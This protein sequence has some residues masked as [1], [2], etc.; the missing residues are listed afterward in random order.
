[1]DQEA[2]LSGIKAMLLRAGGRSERQVLSAAIELL[3]AGSEGPAPATR[4]DEVEDHP[5]NG[6]WVHGESAEQFGRVSYP[7]RNEAIAEGRVLYAGYPF[8]T[9]QVERP[10]AQDFAPDVDQVINRLADSACVL[11][12]GEEPDYTA[13]PESIIAD[14]HVQLGGAVAAWADKWQLHPRF[15]NVV[16][17]ERHVPYV[18]LDRE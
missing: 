9:G 8:W 13:L 14:L 10:C 5:I 1:M 15:F 12:A 11:F 3:E 7:T 6:Y 18:S 16:D 17:L 4:L 2:V